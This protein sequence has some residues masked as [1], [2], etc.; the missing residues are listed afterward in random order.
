MDAL[1]GLMLS[2]MLWISAASGL[3]VPANLP[4]LNFA[5]GP[6]LLCLVEDVALD[7]CV[8]EIVAAGGPTPMGM[9]NTYTH[10]IYMRDDIDLASVQGITTLLHELTHHM[11]TMANVVAN[12]SGEIE[13]TAYLLE[14]QWFQA[15]GFDAWEMMKKTANTDPFTLFMITRCETQ[16]F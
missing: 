16:Y 5:S 8:E 7:D 3:P 13:R 11:Q 10:Q 2:L 15:M 6:E 12:C 4:E 14:L 9:Y 1:S